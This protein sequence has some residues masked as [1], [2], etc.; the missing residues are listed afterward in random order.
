MLRFARAEMTLDL[1][2]DV[3][4]LKGQMCSGEAVVG[5]DLY[6]LAGGKDGAH[7]GRSIDGSALATTGD[8]DALNPIAAQTPAKLELAIAGPIRGPTTVRLALPQAA[9]NGVLE[10]FA[11]D[12]RHVARR[13]LGPLDAG[14][15]V[16]ALGETGA[17][18]PGIYFARVRVGRE[19][20]RA[21]FVVLP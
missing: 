1:T 11:V 12:G 6:Q 20:A 7:G 2:T 4:T 13:E 21:K 8:P 3:L 15:H 9:S 19:S 17:L 5:Y 10:V 18:A 14:E 16:V